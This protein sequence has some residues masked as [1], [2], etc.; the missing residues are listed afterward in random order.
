MSKIL[1]QAVEKVKTLPDSRQEQIGQW[2][3]DVVEQDQSDVQLTTEQQAEVR[4]RLDNPE[5]PVSKAEAD[6]YFR[7]F[8]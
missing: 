7:K 4:R 5:S 2:L 3:L 1:D 6:A 8:V